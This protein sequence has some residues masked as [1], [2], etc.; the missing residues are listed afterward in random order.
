MTEI[1]IPQAAGKA[2]VQVRFHY[3]DA[4]YEWWWEVDNVLIG[5]QVTCVPVDGGLVV[6]N[7]RDKN[8]DSYVNGAT[9]TSKDRPAEKAVTVATP[10]DPGW[11]TASTGCTRR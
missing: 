11:P 10:D 2:Q 1:P 7:V 8:D 4:S 6:G 3:Y 9:V 5:S